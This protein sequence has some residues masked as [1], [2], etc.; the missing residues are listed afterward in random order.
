MLFGIKDATET[1]FAH[2][3]DQT[4]LIFAINS[5]TSFLQNGFYLQ[6]AYL[7]D[8]F[9]KE[10]LQVGWFYYGCM[11]HTSNEPLPPF[12]INRVQHIM[13]AIYI[14]FCCS[15]DEFKQYLH[16]S[17]G[18]SYLFQT[19]CA[20]LSPAIRNLLVFYSNGATTCFD[21]FYEDVMD[22]VKQKYHLVENLIQF[23][24]RTGRND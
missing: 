22:L 13:A 3:L 21:D 20:L 14:I 11:P 2:T 12:P 17:N 1:P 16:V 15:V 10:A 6:N 23:K 8:I 24:L 19:V 18:Y 7:K 5:W 9:S 4:C